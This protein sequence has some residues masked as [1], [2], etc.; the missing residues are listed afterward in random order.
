MSTY[1]IVVSSISILGIAG[2]MALA[3]RLSHYWAGRASAAQGSE[4]DYD[5]LYFEPLRNLLSLDDEEM[6]LEEAQPSAAEFANFRR[7]RRRIFRMYLKELATEFQALHAEARQLAAAAPE[8][9]ADLVGM[10]L[11]QQ[12][13]FWQGLVA[14]EAGLMAESLGLR[15]VGRRLLDTSGVLDLANGMSA[16]IARATAVPGPVPV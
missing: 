15:G 10:L 3:L 16:A 7:E 14:I 12:L 8:E 4:T 6:F 11:G 13:R 1:W 5:A 9:H 2:A